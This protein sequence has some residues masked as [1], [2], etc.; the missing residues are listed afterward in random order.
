MSLRRVFSTEG[1][2]LKH[3]DVVVIG[4]GVAGSSCLYHLAQRGITRTLLVEQAAV[5]AGSSGRSAAFIETQYVDLDRIRLGIY[6]EDLLEGF[7]DE[8]SLPFIQRGKLLLALDAEGLCELKESAE[9]QQQLGTGAVIL[10]AA[11]VAD[12]APQL[13]TD[14]VEG[15]LYGPRDGYIDP[16][17]LCQLFIDLAEQ[18]GAKLLRC[19]VTD[20]AQSNGRVTGVMTTD[21][22]VSCDAL[23]NAAG[24]WAGRIGA[25]AG[26]QVPV[27]GYRREVVVLEDPAGRAGDLPIVV[28]P[29]GSFE[30][31]L[32]LRG[33][34]GGLLL[35][36]MHFEGQT[37]ESAVDP[38]DFE[39]TV[40]WQA[41]EFVSELVLRRYRDGH[42]LGLRVGW[43]G[44]YPLSDDRRPIVGESSQLTGFWNL[45]GLG[46]NGIQLSPGFGAVLADEMVDGTSDLLP[47]VE[48]YRPERFTTSSNA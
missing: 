33:D 9:R 29:L 43:A 38:D 5:A 8:H 20:V 6:A 14:D 15:A 34:G 40:S 26:L 37:D 35:A 24:A 10:T 31:N 28:E 32:Y 42:E 19:R 45:A 41:Q 44:L 39:S 12:V 27:R 7:R 3:F 36:G 25:L 11:Q 21:G 4:A 16:P 13:Q 30:R 47:D 17:R 46:G 18:Q 22:A 1:S 48:P 2:G 23:V